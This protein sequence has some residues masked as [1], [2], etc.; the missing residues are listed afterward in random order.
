MRPD[1]RKLVSQPQ[2]APVDLPPARAG[3][4]GPESARSTRPSSSA[5]LDTFGQAATARAVRASMLAAAIPDPRALTAIGVLIFVLRGLRGRRRPAEIKH[6]EER[7]ELR[8]AA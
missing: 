2:Q 4:N 5:A 8:P 7:V 3:W 1:V 6:P